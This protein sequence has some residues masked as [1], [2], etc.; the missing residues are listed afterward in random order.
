[1]DIQ[2]ESIEEE[3]DDELKDARDNEE[4]G[5]ETEDELS[6]SSDEERE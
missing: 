3:D 4:N 2:I 1:M 6:L 5:S